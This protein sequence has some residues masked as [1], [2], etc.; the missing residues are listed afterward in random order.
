MFA[1]AVAAA[2]ST[3]HGGRAGSGGG[4]GGV[5]S[6]EMRVRSMQEVRLERSI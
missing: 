3:L 5:V 6:D 1:N 4:S 2:A